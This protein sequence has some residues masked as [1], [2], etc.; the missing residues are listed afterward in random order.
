MREDIVIRNGTV[1]DGTGA[2]PL[3]ADVL[4][5]GGHVVEVG[6]IGRRHAAAIDA[7]DLYVTPGFIDIHSHS[8]YTVLVDPRAVSSI[9]QGVTSEIVGNCGYGCFPIRDRETAAGSIYGYTDDVELAWT[10]AEG[11]FERLAQAGPAINIASL[12]PNAQLRMATMRRPGE[13]ATPS[14]VQEMAGLLSDALRA[15]AWG[16]ST[17]LEYPVEEAAT[18]DEV[19]ALCAVVAQV[20]GLYAT[21][22]RGRNDAAE[23]GI[24]EALTAAQRAGVRLQVSHLLPRTGLESGRA[25]MELIEAAR[26]E[27]LDVAFDQHTRSGGFTLLQVGL[28]PAGAARRR[29]EPNRSVADC[30]LAPVCGP[31]Y[32]GHRSG[33]RAGPHRRHL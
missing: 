31:R 24:S 27:G 10:T 5:S 2:E 9:F 12:V 4:I 20:G 8:D 19:A 15:G 32:R 18:P 29:L 11:Y 14:E 1:I 21:H 30:R 17:G 22:T 25:C 13:C 23:E 16:L 33:A 26:A 3:R 28:P 7:T 6:K